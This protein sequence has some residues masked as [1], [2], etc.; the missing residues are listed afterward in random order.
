MEPISSKGSS[1]LYQLNHNHYAS[2]AFFAESISHRGAI[3]YL[4]QHATIILPIFPG[5]TSLVA[6]SR[7]WLILH[8]NRTVLRKAWTAI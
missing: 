6:R 5:V 7:G 3:S 2:A 4:A 8:L 1:R